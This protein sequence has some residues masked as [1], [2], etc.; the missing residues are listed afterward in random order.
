MDIFQLEIRLSKHALD[1]ADERD[2]E[3]EE[4]EWCI[5]TGKMIPSGKHLL[6]FVKEYEY[7]RIECLCEV[8]STCL[9]VITVIKGKK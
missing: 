9:F 8:R 6:R 2:I 4:I 3:L 7:V 5:R 1:R